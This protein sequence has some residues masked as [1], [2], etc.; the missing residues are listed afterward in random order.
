MNKTKVYIY[1]AGTEYSRLLP[2]IIIQADK[3]EVLGIIT[4]H[5]QPFQHMDGYKVMRLEEADVDSADYIII[6]IAEWK[7]IAEILR[8]RGVTSNK[9]IRSS[10]FHLPYFKF[11]EYIKLRES[12]I[13]ILA[14]WCLGGVLHKELG[15]PY[16]SPTINHRC[17]SENGYMEFL[18]DYKKY[19]GMD[20]KLMAGWE[21]GH[22]MFVPRGIIDDKIVWYFAH[23]EDEVKEAEKWN[24][25]RKRVNF[26][27]I[28]ALMLL[29]NEEEA[30]L[31]DELPIEKKLGFYY[32]DL[33]LKSVIPTPEWLQLKGK[34]K[35][36]F[37][38]G[39]Y[40]MKKYTNNY[41]RASNID[42]LRFLNGSKKFLRDSSDYYPM[43]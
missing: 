25:R 8:A 11:E 29:E 17:L 39:L 21:E 34:T 20:I 38:Y 22:H 7:E 1:G 18:R 37:N 35:L 42:W 41:G 14:N 26:E 13:S 30:Y 33:G 15:L 32:K 3:I 5:K 19:L 27:N 12:N 2:H 6:A 40:L 10:V 4:T 23:T 36:E 9:I 16:L 43:Q 28:A 24:E 31:F